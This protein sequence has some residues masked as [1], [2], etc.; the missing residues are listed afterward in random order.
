MSREADVMRL[1]VLGAGTPVAS[2]ERFGSSFVASIGASSVMVD[3]GPAATHKMAKVG[4]SPTEID[5]LL[6]THHHYDHNADLPCFLLHRWDQS[7]G[8]E[9]SLSVCG[10]PPTQRLVEGIIAPEKGLWWDDIAARIHNPGSQRV[11]TNRG[12]SLPRRPP[13][14]EARDMTVGDIVALRSMSIT[15]GAVVHAQPWLES[16]AYRM[17]T[18]AGSV[19]FTGDTG[20]C[21]SVISLA[22]GVDLLVC[23]CWDTSARMRERG[24]GRGASNRTT[25]CGAEEAATIA[26]KAGARSLLLVHSHHNLDRP[27]EVRRAQAE[28]SAIY[29]G[30]VFLGKELMQVELAAG[31]TRVVGEPCGRP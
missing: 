23:M 26:A 15:T 24:E 12:G 18:E 8:S 1:W 2:P 30:S 9:A 11:Y 31:A 16:L 4:L 3:C 13:Q 29:G 6:F 27:D 28:I 10:P 17:E 25:M 20:L 5:C 19:V 7:T 14:V 22:E 21:D